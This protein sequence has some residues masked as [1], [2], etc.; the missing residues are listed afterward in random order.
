MQ[1]QIKGKDFSQVRMILAKEYNL[2]CD[3][4]RLPD[5]NQY[6]C[7]NCVEL[8]P[9]LKDVDYLKPIKKFLNSNKYNGKY[10]Y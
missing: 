9:V 8:P 1:I 10:N 5:S 7:S 3:I 6:I 2:K 4:V